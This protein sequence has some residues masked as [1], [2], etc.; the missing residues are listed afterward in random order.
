M[1]PPISYLTRHPAW[2]SLCCLP[3]RITSHPK[4]VPYVSH[5]PYTTPET[6]LF[7][8][9]HHGRQP[10]FG[11]DGTHGPCLCLLEASSEILVGSFPSFPHW[12][13]LSPLMNL[14]SN[15]SPY[16]VM[17]IPDK[18]RLRRPRSTTTILRGISSNKRSLLK[19][20][21][22]HILGTVHLCNARLHSGLSQPLVSKLYVCP[23]TS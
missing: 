21:L 1:I 6:S 12:E 15:Q 8:S 2:R 11:F 3:G 17:R 9:R 13:S 7:Q 4:Y 18:T 20:C 19:F 14:V 16:Y 23:G 22:H 5:H 10:C